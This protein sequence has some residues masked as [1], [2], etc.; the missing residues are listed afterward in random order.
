MTPDAPWQ[1]HN[2]CAKRGTSRS[3]HCQTAME[4]GAGN[5]DL[6]PVIVALR[7]KLG[8]DCLLPS[9]V[10]HV[11]AL[12]QYVDEIANLTPD[13]RRAYVG[14]SAFAHKGGVHADAV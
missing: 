7:L 2:R 5:C 4:S 10:G 1:R 8:F 14:R 3:G 13:T 11:T 6:I 9:S 12:S